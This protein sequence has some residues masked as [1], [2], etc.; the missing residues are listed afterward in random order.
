MPKVRSVSYAGLAMQRHRK[1]SQLRQN[2]ATIGG[3]VGGRCTALE[4]VQTGQFNIYLLE[5]NQ[6]LM[7]ES[8]DATPGRL[9]LGFHYSDKTTGLHFLHLTVGFTKR[10]WQFRQEIGQLTT[11]R[12]YKSW[13]NKG[14]LLTHLIKR[15]LI[16]FFSSKQ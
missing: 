7:R 11:D 9:G 2:V 4:L 8:S 14:I 10:H 16:P 3:G 13:V 12:L 15:F 6:Q 1:H 5:K